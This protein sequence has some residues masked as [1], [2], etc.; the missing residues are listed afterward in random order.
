MV[1]VAAF[2][3][4]D[5]SQS[6]IP[7]LAVNESELMEV[8]RNSLYPGASDASIKVVIGYCK[9]SNL[10]PM[11]KPVHIVP[12]WDQKSGGMRDVIMPGIGAYRVD[13]SKSG[14]HAG[15][16]E[17]EFG[18]EVMETI[19]GVT[20]SYPQWCRVTVKRLLADGQVA[21]Y[22]AVERWKEN[23]AVKGGKEKSQAP[24]A[25]WFKRPY[26]QLAKC[27]EAQALRKA[28]PEVGSAPTAD[29][30]EGKT[31]NEVDIQSG[32]KLSY[33][34]EQ[35]QE[36]AATVIEYYSDEDFKNKQWTWYATLE[37][38]RQKHGTI[39]EQTA[40]GLINKIQSNGKLFT[41]EQVDTIK[42]W[43]DSINTN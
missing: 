30:M 10:D 8:L 22:P 13:A 32:E 17:P 12:M 25:M 4:I 3:N 24:N 23:Y 37:K 6:T 41:S 20:I 39:N 40:E 2:K 11:R 27:S 35:K 15:T 1:E 31:I 36:Q 16:S 33:T 7:S 26:A 19:D 14:Q 29:E 34:K 28:F 9:V 38:Q 5:D 21:E 42:S 43:V 18:P